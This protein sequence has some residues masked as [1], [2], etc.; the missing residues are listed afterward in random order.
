[1][2]PF[3]R[4]AAAVSLFVAVACRF[5]T[6]AAADDPGGEERPRIV[7]AGATLLPGEFAT[8]DG[9]S[10]GIA[11]ASGI[12]WIGGD[13]YLVAMD[14]HDRLLELRLRLAADGAPVAAVAGGFVELDATRDWEDLAS[15]ETDGSRIVFLVE[16]DTPALRAFRVDAGATAAVAVGTWSLAGVFPGTRPNRG[17]ESLALDADGGGLWTANEEPLAGDGP[18]VVAGS[19]GEV[20]LV[21][22]PLPD[23]AG[24]SF[25]DRREWIYPVGRPHDTLGLPGGPVLA[26]VVA[27][28]ALDRARLLVLE[29]SAGAGVPPFESR[30]VLVEPDPLRTPRGRAE[31]AAA[32]PLPRRVLWRG[33][34]GVNLEGLCQ[35]PPLADGTRILVGIADN[36]A[37]GAPSGRRPPTTL[38]VFRVEE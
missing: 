30:I 17:P 4:T 23:A 6:G 18:A 27:L 38:A 34:P 3:R 28:V 16:E 21:H 37:A 19:A 32:T 22:F 2:G 7:W 12:V 15:V 24:D 36:G 33:H 25:D 14:G 8:G 1:M 29:R 26:G 10:G 35:G 9:G 13:R 31:I 5:P 11:E 20:R